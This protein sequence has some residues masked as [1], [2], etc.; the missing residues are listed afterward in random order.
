MNGKQYQVIGQLSR[1]NRDAPIG[2]RSIYVKNNR[3]EL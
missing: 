2:L 3:N 1:E